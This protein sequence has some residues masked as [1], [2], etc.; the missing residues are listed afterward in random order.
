MTI[1]NEL[2]QKSYSCHFICKELTQSSR[3]LITDKGYKFY[4][5]D[6]EDGVLTIL[7]NLN[8]DYLIVD[9]Y[10]LDAK[11]ESKAHTFS[12]RILV[13]DDMADRSHFCDFL[14]DQGPLRTEADYKPW[15]NPECKL[16]LGSDYTLIKPEFR[17][18]R[19][20]HINSWRKGLISFG[21][22]DPDNIT[23]MILEALDNQ[24]DM[25][26]IKWTIIAGALNQHWRTLKK[27]ISHNQMDIRLIKQTNQ[28]AALMANHDFA[29]GAAGSMAWERACIGIPSLTIPIEYN[30]K[31]GIEVIRHF[32]LGETLEVSELT[33]TTVARAL[34]LLQNQANDYLRRNQAMVDGLGVTRLS[35]TMLSVD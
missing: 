8:P 25:K 28:I 4:L 9:H 31:F 29:I 5:E 32:G 19:K 33:S 10:G 11:F 17:K 21:G 34:E 14:L 18:L 12:K 20:S 3:A 23:L 2:D 35:R 16:L 22:S 13:I 24:L 30:Q 1:A 7:K 15:I 6:N 26:N 27:F